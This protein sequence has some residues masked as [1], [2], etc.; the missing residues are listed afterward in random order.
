VGARAADVGEREFRFSQQRVL[1][2]S[3]ELPSLPAGANTETL[4][5]FV[6]ERDA[7]TVPQLTGAFRPWSF[8]RAKL[9]SLL[10]PEIAIS[11]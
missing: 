2:S 6:L 10:G 4:M 9:M 7:E 1:Y 8:S 3:G 5:L 11:A